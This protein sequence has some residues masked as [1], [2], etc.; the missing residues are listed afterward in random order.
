MQMHR[1]DTMSRTPA[2][3]RKL[4]PTRLES[5]DAV[6]AGHHDVFLA[7]KASVESERWAL[8]EYY[9]AQIAAKQYQP[10]LTAI[11]ELMVADLER[12]KRRR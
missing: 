4:I 10:S 3:R 1:T 6:E 8:V 7:A 11:A 5:D 9:R 2:K 12:S